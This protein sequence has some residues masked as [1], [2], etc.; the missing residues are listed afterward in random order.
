MLPTT[1]AVLV[2]VLVL[3]ACSGDDD[4]AS[5]TSGTRA[6]TTTTTVASTTTTRAA[7]STTSAP[8]ATTTTAAKAQP[9]SPPV[10]GSVAKQTSPVPS[11][12][13][14]L[15]G[16]AVTRD[17]CTDTVTFDF[18]SGA[19]EKPGYTVEYQKGPF[20][21]DGSG[22]PVTVS[23]SAFLVV[24]LEPATGYD[25]VGNR[26]AYTGPTRIPVPNG[27]YTTELVQTGDF[28]SVTTWVIGV[29]T[30]VP[31]SVEGTGAPTHRLTVNIG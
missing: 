12:V 23:G 28:E 29:R 30:Q 10:G 25:F 4:S 2:A 11:D 13:M 3:G 19:P 27:A 15:T 24:R 6:S 18:T 16:V 7:T 1:V 31:F 22:R 21:E 5:S 20:V 9:C 14:V 17:G 26:Q 8:G